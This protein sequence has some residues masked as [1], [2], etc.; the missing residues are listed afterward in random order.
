MS[1]VVIKAPS[2]LAVEARMNLCKYISAAGARRYERL[3]LRKGR[4]HVSECLIL[5]RTA[6]SGDRECAAEVG[7]IAAYHGACVDGQ[8]VA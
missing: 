8:K 3:G 1:E 6:L 5:R 2:S 4:H 7:V